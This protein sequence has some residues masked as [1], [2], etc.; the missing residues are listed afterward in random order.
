MVSRAQEVIF[1]ECSFQGVSLQLIDVANATISRCNFSDYRNYY[2]DQNDFVIVYY[3]GSG[4]LTVRN[5]D[6]VTVVHCNF[7]NNEGGIELYDSDSY[8]VNKIRSLSIKSS[9]FINT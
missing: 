7:S 8:T 5:A 2:D 4:A 1:S 3:P 9:T 6:T